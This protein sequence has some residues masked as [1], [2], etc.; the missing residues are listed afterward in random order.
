MFK[1]DKV[2]EDMPMYESWLEER[3][4][5]PLAGAYGVG[6]KETFVRL[7]DEISTAIAARLKEEYFHGRC[8]ATDDRIEWN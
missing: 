8:D 7:V 5:R 3:V 6:T 4:K 2:G 1:E